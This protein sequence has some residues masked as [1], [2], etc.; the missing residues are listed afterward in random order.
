MNSITGHWWPVAISSEVDRRPVARTRFGQRLVF[1]RSGERVVCMPDRC[2]HRGAALS[3]GRIHNGA[4]VCPFH[5]IEFSAEGRC[6]SVPVEDDPRIPED[7]GVSCL[8]VAEADGYIWLW[9]GSETAPDARPSFPRHP[10]LEGLAYGESTTIWPAHYTRCIENV[11]DFS[12]L[13]FVHRTTIGMG[14]RNR[15]TR[16]EIEDVAGGFRA[17]LMRDGQRG[18]CLEFLYPNLWLLMV[19]KRI[20]LSAVFSPV[21][22]DHT[23]VYGRTYHRLHLPGIKFL[24]DA[25]TRVSQYLVFR[26]D[27]PIVASQRP[28]DVLEAQHEKLFPSD[29]PVM[30][31][32]KLHRAANDVGFDFRN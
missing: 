1:W 13:P 28:G 23:A 5:G 8:P 6:V 30:A 25:Y 31:Y 32:R 15:A 26:E 16:I 14:K 17:H 2:P 24:I 20:L 29:A 12:H 4:I 21:D 18:Q 22:D 11:C 9:R 19:S 27:W 3:Q 7:F 10:A